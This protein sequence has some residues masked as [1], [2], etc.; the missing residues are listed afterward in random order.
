MQG[1]TKM[2]AVSMLHVHVISKCPSQC[3]I[4]VPRFVPLSLILV[5]ALIGHNRILICLKIR[6]RKVSMVDN[7][8]RA[9]TIRLRMLDMM[10]NLTRIADVERNLHL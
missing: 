2:V 4:K 3:E 8:C 10:G 5:Q 1:K 7:F 9:S 6:H